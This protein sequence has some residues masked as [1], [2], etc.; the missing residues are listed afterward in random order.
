MSHARLSPSGGHRWGVCP[1]SVREETGL[2]DTE[3]P[4]A[5]DGTR[6]HKLLEICVQDNLKDPML[7]LGTEIECEGETFKVDGDRA[8]RVATAISYIRGRR[9]QLSDCL[10]R[11]EGQVDAGI[12][13]GRDDIKGT[14]DVQLIGKEILEIIDYKDGMLPV[15]AENNF[16]LSTYMLG[17][18]HQ[19]L[20][21]TS[22]PFTEFKLTVIQPKMAELGRDPISSWSMD[23]SGFRKFMEKLQKAAIATDSADAPLIP[24]EV[25][26]RWCKAKGTC[27]ALREKA[28]T[29]AQVLFEG[30]GLSS[31]QE[32]A[33][34]DPSNFDD[35][36]LGKII[37]SLPL[38]NQFL[39]AVQEEALRR[40]TS[41]TPI[42]GLKVVHGRGTREWGVDDDALLAKF[43]SLGIPKDSM[44]THKLLS[45]AQCEKVTWMTRKDEKK[46]LSERQLTGLKDKFI[47]RTPGKLT[48]VPESDERKAAIFDTEKLF[49]G[50]EVGETP[51]L[52]I[53]NWLNS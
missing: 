29:D 10:V 49:S 41:G 53:P 6:T 43:K 34:E 16:Q 33:S 31:P 28:L 21:G 5:K 47:K 45:P 42:P 26:C 22:L 30:T 4:A 12:W 37:E 46:S 27:P 51:K 24:G 7:L 36:K 2:P 20:S 50:V 13:L 32:I 8:A 11:A 17:A 1:G 19:H 40:L 25:Q 23:I 35:V 18:A 52:A 48:V 44:Y 15:D 14:V 38:I 39:A 9:N 3:S